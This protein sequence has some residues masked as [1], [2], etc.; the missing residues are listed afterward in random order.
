M[1]DKATKFD[2]QCA[3]DLKGYCQAHEGGKSFDMMDPVCTERNRMMN[4]RARKGQISTAAKNDST[5][6]GRWVILSHVPFEGYDVQY[7]YSEADA[8]DEWGKG[9][10]DML[11]R[12]AESRDV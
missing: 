5:V 6:E 4:E 2:S 10:G 11:G 1:T 8:R 7:F 9:Y 3:F 12:I